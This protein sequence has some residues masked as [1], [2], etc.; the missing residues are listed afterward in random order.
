MKNPLLIL[1]RLCRKQARWERLIIESGVPAVILRYF[2]V[3]G[4][5]QSEAYAGVISIFIRQAILGRDIIIY[6]DG[7][8]TRDFIFVDDIVEANIRAMNYKS[9]ACEIFNISGGENISIRELAEKIIKITKD[10]QG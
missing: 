9:D 3:Y 8:Q 10:P 5:G 2:N 1:N 6:G 4:R 7:M